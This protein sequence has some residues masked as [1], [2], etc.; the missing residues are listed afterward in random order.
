MALRARIMR[1]IGQTGPRKRSVL[2]GLARGKRQ[3]R[4]AAKLVDQM[5]R[6]GELVNVSRSRKHAIY[7]IRRP[8][9]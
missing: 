5:R 9:A 1:V 7:D 6:E 2:I 8:P 4:A 3:Q